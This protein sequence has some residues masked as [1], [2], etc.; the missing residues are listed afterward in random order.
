MT[1]YQ[2]EVTCLHMDGVVKWLSAWVDE[3]SWS[4][5]LHAVWSAGY[6][7][8]CNVWLGCCCALLGSV[9]HIPLCLVKQYLCKWNMWSC[10]MIIQCLA[11]I[12]KLVSRLMLVLSYIWSQVCAYMLGHVRLDY[13]FMSSCKHEQQSSLEHIT[14][15]WWLPYIIWVM[16]TIGHDWL[17]L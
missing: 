10:S 14:T 13:E 12:P 6:L 8:L 7:R 15:L 4:L 1:W 3:P 5:V 11:H 17:L 16:G 2:Q 9:T